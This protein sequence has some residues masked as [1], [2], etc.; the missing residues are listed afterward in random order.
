MKAE[1][2]PG[3]DSYE[4]M[5]HATVLPDWIASRQTVLAKQKDRPEAVSL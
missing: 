3:G 2:Y 4:F 5:K 1:E